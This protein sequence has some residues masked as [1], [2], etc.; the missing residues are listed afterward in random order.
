MFIDLVHVTAIFFIWLD[1]NKACQ[2]GILGTLH[3]SCSNLNVLQYS[4]FKRKKKL[5]EGDTL[6]KQANEAI[7]M[8]KIILY[9]LSYMILQ[10]VLH[11]GKKVSGSRHIYIDIIFCTRC[12]VF[13]FI[14]YN[15]LYIY[16]VLC[17]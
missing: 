4:Y 8:K 16:F 14:N 17:R 15:L 7:Y 5:N 10:N 6:Y 13:L 1:H 3:R 11:N 9:I 2:F 12:F